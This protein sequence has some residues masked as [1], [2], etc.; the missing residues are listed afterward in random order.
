[1]QDRKLARIHT[2]KRRFAI[3]L[4]VTLLA[5]TLGARALHADIPGFKRVE[6]QQHDTATAGHEAILAR[7]EFNPG[8][9]VPKH[10]HP[11]EEV[12]YV[13]EGQILLEVEGKPAQTL[14][15]GD[16]FFIPAGQVHAAKNT[17]TTP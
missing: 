1:M 4:A 15:P 17:G 2:R 12:A 11:G 8:A 14:K 3:G 6:L 16:T 9:A 7:G 5:A 10:T 13:L